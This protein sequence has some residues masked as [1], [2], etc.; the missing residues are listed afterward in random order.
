MRQ[1]MRLDFC[2]ACSLRVAVGGGTAVDKDTNELV[3][4]L[5]T[6]AGIVM[7]DSSPIAVSRLP[8]AKHKIE[9]RL[10]DLEQ[11]ARDANVLIQA[12]QILARRNIR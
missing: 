5:S 6:A 10:A 8:K 3:A 9:A 7:E 1:K 11:A 4:R 12:A 2:R